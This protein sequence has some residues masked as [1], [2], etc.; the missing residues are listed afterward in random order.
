MARV[1]RC[2]KGLSNTCMFPFNSLFLN[3]AKQVV[4]HVSVIRT[5]SYKALQHL[6]FLDEILAALTH[7]GFFYLLRQG[8]N[9]TALTCLKPQRET[10]C[11]VGC[12][13]L[14]LNYFM[15]FGDCCL[16]K[17]TLHGFSLGTSVL[18]LNSAIRYA[19][20]N[21]KGWGVNIYLRTE[22]ASFDKIPHTMWKLLDFLLDTP[23]P[24][25]S[26]SGQKAAYRWLLHPPM[27]QKYMHKEV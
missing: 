14:S 25:P 9:C 2:L 17:G 8:E 23:K 7:W 16:M 12:R 21:S 26:V 10:I 15:G 22:I 5:G 3:M 19:G 4:V 27:P 18:C 6:N 20:I 13:R 11:T 24:C 1:R